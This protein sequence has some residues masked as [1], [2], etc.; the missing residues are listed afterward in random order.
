[1][2]KLFLLA[3]LILGSLSAVASLESFTEACELEEGHIQMRDYAKT[4]RC[5]LSYEGVR[6]DVLVPLLKACSEDLRKAK[7]VISSHSGWS[8]EWTYIDCKL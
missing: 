3:M 1:M 2:K 7:L 8:A 6:G 5:E 4:A